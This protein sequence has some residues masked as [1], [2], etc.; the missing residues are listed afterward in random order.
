ME[1]EYIVA[2][3]DL[4]GFSDKFTN[5]WDRLV[6][7]RPHLFDPFSSCQFVFLGDYVDGGY[8]TAS[9]IYH[10]RLIEGDYPCVFLRGNHEQMMLDAKRNYRDSASV[11]YN[12][13]NQGGRATSLSYMTKPSYQIEEDMDWF[14][15]LPF[16]YETEN[17][18]FVHAGLRPN[19]NSV[20]ETP[21]QEKMW[22]R[23]E[24]LNS[25]Y[26]WWGKRVI[27]GHTF[28]EKPIVKPNLICMDTMWHTRGN[29]T[30]AI[31]KY[32]DPTYV[33]FVQ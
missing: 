1:T 25:D 18:I 27:A 10:L 13:Y 33:E 12:W 24:F 9:L 23:D 2:F 28:H 5:L 8:Q 7:T 3:G 20:D 22:I 6:E 15:T 14:E 4:H 19:T 31:L 16:V 29:P 30:A 17:H 26:S 32:H 21:D 11:H